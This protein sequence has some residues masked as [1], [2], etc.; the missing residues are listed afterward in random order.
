MLRRA[1]EAA[2]L[3][4][5]DLS[6][7]T[8]IPKSTLLAIESSDVLRLP[9]E[10]YTRGF[11]KAY[12]AE[13]GLPPERA[14]DDYLGA[15]EPP[16]AHQH[17]VEEGELATAGDHAHP[18]SEAAWQPDPLLT[19]TRRRRT[20][21]LTTIAAGIG[22]IA[23]VALSNRGDR[24]DRAI[25]SVEPSPAISDAT[26]AGGAADEPVTA[27]TPDAVPAAT[28]TFRLDITT[29]G[30]CWIAATVDGQRVIA[31]LFQAGERQTLAFNQEAVL[32]VGQP[33]ALSFSINGQGGRALGAP[34]QPISVR[35][36][37]DNFREFLSS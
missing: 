1:R 12:A 26:R 27:T 22:L 23:Y 29:Q 14:A 24:E 11:V 8:K 33:G 34:G 31:K 35:I 2:G 28:D 9:A 3:S 20:R 5:Q 21:V 32:R 18:P 30:P 16:D 10:I 25:D 17:V 13:V 15:I 36:T 7:T 4:L 37:K 19:N 6:R